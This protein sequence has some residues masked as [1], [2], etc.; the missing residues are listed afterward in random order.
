MSKEHLALP[1][2]LALPRGHGCIFWLGGS[3]GSQHA[4]Q[5]AGL[6]HRHGIYGLA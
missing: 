6:Q 1:L 2:T 4:I 5:P 3:M